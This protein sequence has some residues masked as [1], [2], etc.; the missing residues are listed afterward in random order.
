MFGGACEPVKQKDLRGLRGSEEEQNCPAPQAGA[1][2]STRVDASHVPNCAHA[3]YE[4][5]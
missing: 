3:T 4:Q 1:I 2:C 5:I